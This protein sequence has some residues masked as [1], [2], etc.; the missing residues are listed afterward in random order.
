MKLKTLKD[1]ENLNAPENITTLFGI[2]LNRFK[3]LI[4]LFYE[5]GYKLQDTKEWKALK[6]K[7]FGKID[8]E[9]LK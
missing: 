1:L 9:D 8:E 4:D 7:Y 2:S 3:E 6:L 5:A